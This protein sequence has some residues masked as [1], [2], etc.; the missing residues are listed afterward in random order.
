M[1]RIHLITARRKAKLTQAELAHRIG[2]HQSFISKLERGEKTDCTRD[3]AVDLGR[4]LGVDP[5][6]LRF[7]PTRTEAEVA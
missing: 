1:K 2:K 7:G 4:E 3:E 5:L 6:A